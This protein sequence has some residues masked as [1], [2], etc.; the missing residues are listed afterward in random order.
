MPLEKLRHFFVKRRGKG[1]YSRLSENKPKKRHTHITACCWPIPTTVEKGPSNAQ[2]AIRLLLEKAVRSSRLYDSWE[3]NSTSI[4]KWKAAIDACEAANIPFQIAV[5]TPLA[6]GQTPLK[7]LTSL[8]DHEALHFVHSCLR[9]GFYSG[10]VFLGDVGQ[11][12]PAAVVDWPCPAAQLGT[13]YP[14]RPPFTYVGGTKMGHID[15][16]GVITWHNGNTYVGQWESKTVWRWD[17]PTSV[18]LDDKVARQSTRLC[19][20]TG[21][22]MLFTYVEP[23][24]GTFSVCTESSPNLFT[25]DCSRR[26]VIATAHP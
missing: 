20:S 8:H 12:R 18:N 23:W 3:S 13:I 7:A 22:D 26:A 11:A 24:S 5:D 1:G 10:G 25:R 16:Y 6:N 15:G 19:S 14:K 21:E 9:K 2:K 17:S 4:K